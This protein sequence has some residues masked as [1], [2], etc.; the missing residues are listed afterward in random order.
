MGKATSR[1]PADLRDWDVEL[2]AG[3]GLAGLMCRTWRA[4]EGDPTA[5]PFGD[6]DVDVEV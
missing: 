3:R 4:R 5:A 2:M 1:C 6:G